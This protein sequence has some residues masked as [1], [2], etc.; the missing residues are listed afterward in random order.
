MAVPPPAVVS[1]QC[2]TANPPVF[3]ADP[4]SAPGDRQLKPSPCEVSVA[5]PSPAPFVGAPRTAGLVELLGAFAS[6]TLSPAALL[7]DLRAAA[8]ALP[9]GQ[10]GILRFD[11]AA[12]MAARE[13]A[14]RWRAGTAR[15]L[16]GIPFAV[17]DIIDVEG[18]AVTCGSHLAGD[19]I[20]E[21]DAPVIACLRAAGAIPFAMA[22]TT[23]Y[24]AGSPFNPRFGTVTNPWN[25][26]RWTGGSST[27]SGAVL[28]ARLAPFALGTDTG[29]SIRVP[30]AWC[31]VT[32][33]KPTR[34]RVSRDGV[35]CLSW[36]LDHVGPMARSAIDIARI[37]P[38]M[39]EG[40]DVRLTQACSDLATAPR[41]GQTL[42]GL[43][44]GVA[45]GWFTH[46]VDACVL[47]KWRAMLAVAQAAG[48]RLVDLPAL[49][50]EEWHDAG[51]TILLSELA[52]HHRRHMHRRSE[53][54][55]GFLA[56]LET[57]LRFSA[58]DYGEAL[59]L[60]R[61]AIDA[62]DDVFAQV[63]LIMTPGLGGE[64][65]TL[66]GLRVSIDDEDLPFQEVISRNTMVF[67]LTG[68][69]ALMMPSG[70][71]RQDLPTAVQI[72]AARGKDDLCLRAGITL[73]Q[74][75]AWH[76]SIPP[77]AGIEGA[78]K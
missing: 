69:P 15:P 39:A 53:Y 45:S 24:A 71:G 75:T 35:A 25:A 34:S 13:S 28:A 2:G 56:R 61:Q 16:E 5:P 9:A 62:F 48:A 33:L 43:T 73:Q 23:E 60:R 46:R 38:F 29:G 77:G 30:S 54:D 76:L 26:G 50:V 3:P 49:P 47:E 41:A 31:G 10:Q 1:A 52:A 67:D 40:P 18:M 64:A 6:G 42:S 59:A 20:A 66:Q 32:G 37:L 57:G 22:A 44:I 8:A 55:A 12:D 58:A 17:K 70:F 65:G 27:G 74:R 19:R 68:L 4:F 63:D 7:Q 21:H 14:R 36:T 51:W 11:P 78:G 72:V